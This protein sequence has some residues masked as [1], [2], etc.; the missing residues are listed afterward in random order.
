V[1]GSGP[2][3]QGSIGE[4]GCPADPADRSTVAITKPALGISADY[5][6]PPTPNTSLPDP[7]FKESESLAYTKA[8]VDTGE[9]VIRGGSHLDFSFIPNQAFG[10]SLR[11][12]DVTDWYMTAWF[13]RY[14]KDDPTADN[15]LLSQRWRDD[16]VEA[17]VDPNHDPNAFSFYYYSRL[18]IGLPGGGRFVCEDLRDGCAGMVPEA[19]D[20]FSGNYSYVKIDTSRDAAHGAGA[21]LKAGSSLW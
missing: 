6:L 19:D 16:P 21:A 20:G 15:R 13:D 1:P 7:T 4:S 12:P 10:A 17:G 8:G 3:P 14:L 9:I 18:D 5:G 11:G 2:S